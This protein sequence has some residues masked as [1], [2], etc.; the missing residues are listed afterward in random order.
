MESSWGESRLP[1]PC[2]APPLRPA[3]LAPVPTRHPHR[4]RFPTL[5][6]GQ[7]DGCG[8]VLCAL[9]RV[10]RRVRCRSTGWL[11]C[12]GCFYQHERGCCW[13]APC[14][15][16]TLRTQRCVLAAGTTCSRRLPNPIHH[17]VA[18]AHRTQPRC[19]TVRDRRS[20]LDWLRV[21]RVRTMPCE[22][23]THQLYRCGCWMR[24][25]FL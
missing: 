21:C 6:A 24:R 17:A 25:R 5:V 9:L 22:P 19:A 15:T 23:P 14:S 4:V 10:S 20:L 7:G 13:G 16:S 12:T 18:D 2:D 11:S 8:D 3:A 1:Q